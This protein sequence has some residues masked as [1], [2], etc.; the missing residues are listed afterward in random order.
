MLRQSTVPAA[1]AVQVRWST[2][3]LEGGENRVDIDLFGD[4][5]G[6]RMVIDQS[7]AKDS[8]DT[9]ATGESP[10]LHA[11]HRI[12]TSRLDRPGARRG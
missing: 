3:N 10:N 2:L 8:D 1:A 4:P 5:E 11:G 6:E 7:I 9:A 12:W